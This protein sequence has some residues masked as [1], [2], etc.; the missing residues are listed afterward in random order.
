MKNML[1]LYC[2]KIRFEKASK[3]VVFSESVDLFR[4]LTGAKNKVCKSLIISE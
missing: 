4:F 2:Y 1:F 3:R